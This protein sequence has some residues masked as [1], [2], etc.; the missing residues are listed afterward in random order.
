MPGFRAIQGAIG[1][2]RADFGPGTRPRPPFNQPDRHDPKARLQRVLE[3][4]LKLV[5]SPSPESLSRAAPRTLRLKPT[6]ATDTRRHDC[7]TRP[8]SSADYPYAFAASSNFN[9]RVVIMCA[10]SAP[11]GFLKN[12]SQAAADSLLSKGLRSPAP[13][14]APR[15]GSPQRLKRPSSAFCKESSDSDVP[16]CSS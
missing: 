14:P 10:F 8:I 6:P 4:Q 12:S 9:K 16:G 11:G 13:E 3:R 15:A 7:S 1:L 2:L 5:D